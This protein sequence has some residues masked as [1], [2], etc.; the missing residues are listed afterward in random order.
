[1]LGDLLAEDI[2]QVTGRR[3]PTGAGQPKV[4]VSFET[5][6]T[7]LGIHYTRVAT[8]VAVARPD[9]TLYGEGRHDD[10]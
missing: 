4:E 9:G 7:L 1:M 10:P 2:G 3:V 5:K 8:C 6:G